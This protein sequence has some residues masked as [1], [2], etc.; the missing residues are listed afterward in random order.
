M[1]VF[2]FS[3][4]C[5]WVVCVLWLKGWGA[6]VMGWKID[7]R[8]TKLCV[9][10]QKQSTHRGAG[11][12]KSFLIRTIRQMQIIVGRAWAIVVYLACFIGVVSIQSMYSIQKVSNRSESRACTLSSTG[13]M[14][15]YQ[16]NFPAQA[17]WRYQVHFPAGHRHRQD[18]RC[19]SRA[20]TL[21]K[22][23]ETIQYTSKHD[24][25]HTCIGRLPAAES[26][27]LDGKSTL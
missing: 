8:V 3:W 11:V 7:V 14:V 1:Y 23:P 21:S 6:W 9:D 16:S 15:R 27:L 22:T 18:G 20:C 17:G 4:G 24:Y 10:I 5:W 26:D 19:Q 13:R 12:G 25:D 2:T